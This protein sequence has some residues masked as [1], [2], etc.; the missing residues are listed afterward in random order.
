VARD[1]RKSPTLTDKKIYTHER[2][3]ERESELE[4]DKRKETIN[5]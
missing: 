1:E 2:E 4:K 5:S 3:G